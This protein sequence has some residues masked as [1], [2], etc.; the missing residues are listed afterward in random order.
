MV[1]CGMRIH[2]SIAALLVSTG[3]LWCATL[4]ATDALVSPNLGK[5]LGAEALA[6]L[7][8]A[9]FPD[10]TGL[11]EGEGNAL[12]GEQVFDRECASCHGRGGIGGSAMELIGDRSLLATEYP[13]KGIAVYW[14]YGPPLFDYIRR[15]M[16]PS[17]PY[18]LSNDEVYAVI[19]Y[20]LEHSELLEEGV[21]L[22]AARLSAII[23]PN[24]DNFTDVYPDR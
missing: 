11:P 10:G 24:R 23:M 2:N 12:H 18:S 3:V 13:D 4:T 15:S 1:W 5:E 16:P 20:L 7:P 21:S 17:L 6:K 9:I 8:S 14:P 22:D 19:A